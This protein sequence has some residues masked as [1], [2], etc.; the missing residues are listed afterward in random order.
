MRPFALNLSLSAFLLVFSCNQNIEELG[1]ALNERLENDEIDVIETLFNYQLTFK[2]TQK[3]DFL[4]VNVGSNFDEN[5]LSYLNSFE[6]KVTVDD[7]E[8]YLDDNPN[9]QL[10]S[11]SI[12]ENKRKERLDQGNN[13]FEIKF[14]DASF[15]LNEKS[16]AIKLEPISDIKSQLQ[17]PQSLTEITSPSGHR[18]GRVNRFFVF[19]GNPE[20][21]NPNSNPGYFIAYPSRRSCG[22]CFWVDEWTQVKEFPNVGDQL[23]FGSDSWVRVRFR[24][25][26]DAQN[27]SVFFKSNASDPW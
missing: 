13:N 10:E 14:L 8:F 20:L 7:L 22:L 24:I 5:L 23:V 3:E 9:K 27:F 21:N 12:A 4:V 19:G 18:W 26:H 6:I 1:P 15:P 25:R 17:F 16:I 2:D 11:M